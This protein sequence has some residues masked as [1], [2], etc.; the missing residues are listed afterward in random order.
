MS[1]Q[2][3]NEQMINF[4]DVVKDYTPRAGNVGKVLLP[5]DGMFMAKFATLEPT[6]WESKDNDT[7]F[8]VRGRV[9]ILDEDS[10]GY[11]AEFLQAMTGTDNNG[12]PNSK[13]ILDIFVAGGYT[14]DQIKNFKMHKVSEIIAEMKKLTFGVNIKARAGDTDKATGRKYAPKSHVSYFMTATT[15]EENKKLGGN[16]MRVP[17][18]FNATQNVA[19]TATTPGVVNTASPVPSSSNGSSVGNGSSANNLLAAL[20]GGSGT[21]RSAIGRS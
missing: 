13:R 20:G 2:N 1:D 18:S 3:L 19:A 6:S 16:I 12:E 11:F 21:L 5:Y 4:T 17:H 10:K 9:Q 8:A 15:Y 7:V 14:V